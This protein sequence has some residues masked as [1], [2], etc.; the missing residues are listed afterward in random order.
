MKGNQ[1][2]G[3]ERN[4]KCYVWEE[5]KAENKHKEELKMK[6]NRKFI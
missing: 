4:A 3:R 6:I 2:K 5:S 1:L